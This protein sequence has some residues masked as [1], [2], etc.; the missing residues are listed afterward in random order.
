ML[1]LYFGYETTVFL[2]NGR[3]QMREKQLYEG[4]QHEG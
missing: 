2:P 3:K 4:D 1:T